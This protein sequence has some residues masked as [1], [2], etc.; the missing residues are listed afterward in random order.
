MDAPKVDQET[1]T[2]LPEKLQE[3]HTRLLGDALG[4]LG[5]P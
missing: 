4:A 5:G 3:A 1:I 2:R